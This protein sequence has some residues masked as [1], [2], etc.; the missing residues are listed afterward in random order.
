MTFFFLN[1]HLNL[2]RGP[3]RFNGRG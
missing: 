1:Q 2:P 3:C